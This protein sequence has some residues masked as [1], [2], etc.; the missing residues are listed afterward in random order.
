MAGRD[1]DLADLTRIIQKQS[2]QLNTAYIRHWLA[3][4]ADLLA[5]DEIAQRFER[6][7]RAEKRAAREARQSYRTKR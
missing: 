1:K 7:W 5:N 2:D 4:F 3:I 6:A